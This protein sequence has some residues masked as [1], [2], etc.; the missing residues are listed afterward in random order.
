MCRGA[1]GRVIWTKFKNDKFSVKFL[2][3]SLEPIS[4][5]SFSIGVIW[6][7][8]VLSEVGFFAWEATWGRVLWYLLFSLFGM[9]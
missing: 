8:W 1:E 4:S 7:S 2:C 3:S 9:S 6:N 5:L